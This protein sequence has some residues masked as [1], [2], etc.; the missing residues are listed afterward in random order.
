MIPL[1]ELISEETTPDEATVHS[2]GDLQKVS[3]P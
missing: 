2:W 1:G 3:L